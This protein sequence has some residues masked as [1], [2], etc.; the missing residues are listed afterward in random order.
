MAVRINDISGDTDIC[1]TATSLDQCKGDTDREVF[2]LVVATGDVITMGKVI[3]YVA[4]EATVKADAKTQCSHCDATGE[5]KINHSTGIVGGSKVK[6]HDVELCKPC[7]GS[8][9]ISQRDIDVADACIAA[10][11]PQS[12]LLDLVD[13]LNK[14]GEI[15]ASLETTCEGYEGYTG[16]DDDEDT[17]LWTTAQ[18]M[19]EKLQEIYQ[20]TMMAGDL[21][22]LQQKI[23]AETQS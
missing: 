3:G 7:D 17:D 23:D 8:G 4:N 18:E 6:T 9:M 13:H 1:Y 14:A 11:E 19:I 12:D 22:D 16:D 2:K 21:E 15:A 5:I 10:A 20:T